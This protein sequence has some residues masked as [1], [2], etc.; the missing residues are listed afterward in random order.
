LQRRPAEFVRSVRFEER[1][2]GGPVDRSGTGEIR[3]ERV[4]DTVGESMSADASP[5]GRVG[6]L[7]VGTR[8]QAGAGEVLVAVRGGREA[9]M[10]WSPEPLAKG[11]DVLVIAERGPRTV[12]VEEWTGFAV[13]ARVDDAH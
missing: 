4:A 12:T 5:V 3:D 7:V 1:T 8:G 11:T 6:Q 2:T 10:A 9:F 13:G